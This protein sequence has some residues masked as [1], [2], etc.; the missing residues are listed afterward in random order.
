MDGREG[1]QVTKSM[2]QSVAARHQLSRLCRGTG[3]IL[4]AGRRAGDLHEEGGDGGWCVCVCVC[5]HAWPFKCVCMY[6][7]AWMVDCVPYRMG[8]GESGFSQMGAGLKGTV[9]VIL[10]SQQMKNDAA[11]TQSCVDDLRP[12]APL[13]KNKQNLISQVSVSM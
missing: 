13:L 7:F 3:S 6:V 5:A 12:L 1:I 10:A 4:S 8:L 2:S 9:W 11:L